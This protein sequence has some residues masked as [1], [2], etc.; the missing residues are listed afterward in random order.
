[1]KRILLVAL[2]MLVSSVTWAAPIYFEISG[3]GTATVGGD[4]YT[5][6]AFTIRGQGDTSNIQAAGPGADF[7]NLDQAE[8]QFAGGPVYTISSSARVFVNR[9]VDAV[10]FSRGGSGGADLYNGVGV[11]VTGWNL[12]TA[13]GPLSSSNFAIVD[14]WNGIN[15][16]AGAVTFALASNIS[17]TFEARMSPFP[18]SASTLQAVPVLPVWGALLMAAIMPLIV[19]AR[20]RR[21]V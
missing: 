12:D 2:M 13:I 1:M 19:A 17:G 15:T 9:S 5:D 16:D 21:L 18:A 14:N 20:R 11:G 8:I 3:S 4:S 10:G 7:V 6:T